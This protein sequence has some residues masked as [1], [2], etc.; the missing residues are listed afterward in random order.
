MIMKNTRVAILVVLA[1]LALPIV[2]GAQAAGRISVKVVDV[3]GNPISDVQVTITSSGL[4]DYLET[5]STNKKGKVL[6][7]HSDPTLAYTYKFEKEGFQPVVEVLRATVRG[8]TQKTVVMMPAG[9]ARPGQPVPPEH[10]AVLA[11][12]AGAEAQVAGDLETATERYRRAAELDPNLAIAHTGLAGIFFLQE[13]WPEAV[14]EA[15]MALELDPGDQR[16]LQLRYEALMS[17]G[18]TAKA[19]EAAQALA[20]SGASAEVAGRAY[21]DAVDAYQAGDSA[22]ARR[23]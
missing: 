13:R 18:E 12:N 17:A 11:Y 6:M 10:Q 20:G 9:T 14:A 15:E 4:E 5:V 2:A 22:K 7:S 23:R 21:N 16:A 19:A 8:V 3:E 1:V